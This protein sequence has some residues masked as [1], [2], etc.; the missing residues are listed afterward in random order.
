[1]AYRGFFDGYKVKPFDSFYLSE[2]LESNAYSFFFASVMMVHVMASYV[3]MERT[4]LL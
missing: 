1:M 4:R 3:E 2:A